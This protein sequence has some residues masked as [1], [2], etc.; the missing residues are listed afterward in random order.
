MKPDHPKPKRPP[1][2]WNIVIH[3]YLGYFFFGLTVIYA[4]SGLA[5]NHIE[6]WNPNYTAETRE[7]KIAPLAQ[8][9]NL[10]QAEAEALFQQWHLDRSFNPDNVFYPDA[11]TIQIILAQ[12]EKITIHPHDQTAVLE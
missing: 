12:N 4:I 9:D 1:R 11:E 5:V 7:V 6:D 10:T 8:P 3:R 2:W